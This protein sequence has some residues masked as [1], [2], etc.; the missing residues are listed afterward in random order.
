MKSLFAALGFLTILPLPARCHG[1]E[2]DLGRSPIWF[3]LVGAMIGGVVALFDFGLGLFLPPTV[4]SAF[5]VLMMLAASGGLHMD[6]LADTADGFFSSRGRERMLEIM[7]DSRSGPMGIMAIC[8]LLLLKTVTLAAVPE[9]L[10]TS[11]LVLMPLAGRASLTVSLTALPYART[12]GGLAGVFSTDGI[13]AL[14]AATALMAGGWL[15]QSYTGLIAA[16]AAL[17]GTLLL[18]AYSKKKIGGFTGD[19]L[20]ATCELVEFIPALVAAALGTVGG[21]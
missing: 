14:L 15:L 9:P 12:T 20:G 2:C 6:G 11:T 18:A 19:T 7:R 4:V 13:Q 16:M 21:T 10:R 17:A 5:S 8:G 1:N 3:P